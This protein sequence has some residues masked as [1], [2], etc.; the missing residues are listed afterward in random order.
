MSK[1]DY[2]KPPQ[3]YQGGIEPFDYIASWEMNY[4]QGNVVKYITRYKNKNAPLEDLKKARDYINKLLELETKALE[5][6]EKLEKK[7][8]SHGEDK[9]SMDNNRIVFGGYNGLYL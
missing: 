5:K 3:H 8:E 2:R 4:F 6:N 1:K 9:G 7:E